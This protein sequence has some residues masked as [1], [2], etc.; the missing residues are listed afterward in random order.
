MGEAIRSADLRIENVGTMEELK[1]KVRAF[2]KGI[3]TKDT[4]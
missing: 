2:L 3:Q 4:S 1:E